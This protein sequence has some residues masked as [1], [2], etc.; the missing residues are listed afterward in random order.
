MELVAA[1]L[2]HHLHLSATIS[3]I[4]QKLFATTRIS[5]TE[6]AFGVRFETPPRAVEFTLMSSSEK[7]FDSARCPLALICGP[8][9]PANESLFDPPPLTPKVLASPRPVTLG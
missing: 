9:S 7:L 5:A 3:S 6:S 8:F 2:R 1:G 4:D